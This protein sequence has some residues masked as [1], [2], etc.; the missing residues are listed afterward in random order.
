MKAGPEIVNGNSI[1]RRNF[2]TS[3][4]R[5]TIGRLFMIGL[6]RA[7]GHSVIIAASLD[8]LRNPE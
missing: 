8:S 4:R 5:A 7:Q 2:V 6:V 3:S 1:S